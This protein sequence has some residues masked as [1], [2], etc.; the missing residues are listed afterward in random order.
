MNSISRHAEV[1]AFAKATVDN[2]LSRLGRRLDPRSPVDAALVFLAARALALADAVFLLAK[3]GRAAESAPLCLTVI[4]FSLSME[5][6]LR[7]EEAARVRAW[8]EKSSE[9]G[10]EGL[11]EGLG[12]DMEKAGY[13]ERALS[14]ARRAKR[15]FLRGNARA[16]PWIHVFE[17][18]GGG[19]MSPEDVMLSALEALGRAVE[20]LEARWPG[21]FSG[22]REMREK[23]TRQAKE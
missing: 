12:R 10:W 23:V 18:E 2:G 4:R 6:A 11:W 22:A 8:I 7:P 14:A 19:E 5:E 13:S 3:G 15:A 20:A 17:E 9:S 1:L 16:L 21:S